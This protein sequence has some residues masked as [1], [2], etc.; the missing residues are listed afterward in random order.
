MGLAQVGDLGVLGV[1]QQAKYILE[2]T[3]DAGNIGGSWGLPRRGPLSLP[4]LDVQSAVRTTMIA[5]A[6]G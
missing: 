5:G 1:A 4:L 2:G 6:L 3:D